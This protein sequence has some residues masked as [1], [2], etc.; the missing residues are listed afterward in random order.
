MCHN[1]CFMCYNVCFGTMTDESVLSSLVKFRVTK[2]KLGGSNLNDISDEEMMISNLP[3]LFANGYPTCLEKFTLKQLEKFVPFMLRCS[4]GQNCLDTYTAPKWWPRD[5][6]FSVFAKKPAGMDDTRWFTTLKG[7]VCRCYTYHGCEF[8]LRFCTELSKCPSSAYVFV[9]SPDGTTS[10]FSKDTGRLV[11]TFR[12]ENRDYD[13]EVERNSHRWLAP[14]GCSQNASHLKVQPP[15]FDIYLCDSC[16]GEFDSLKEVQEHEKTCGKRQISQEAALEEQP[17]QHNQDSFMYYFGLNSVN[18]EYVPRAMSPMKKISCKGR[19]PAGVTFTRCCGVPFSS[20]LG[21]VI[22]KKSRVAA[23]NPQVLLDRMERY[24][25]TKS[26]SPSCRVEDKVQESIEWPITWK[27]PN[28][29]K[30]QNTWIHHYCF[31]VKESLEKMNRKS[32]GGLNKRSQKLLSMCRD[33]RVVLVRLTEDDIAELSTKVL[34]PEL[35][36]RDSESTFQLSALLSNTMCAYNTSSNIKN[37]YPESFVLSPQAVIPVIDLCSTDEEDECSLDKVAH[38]SSVP[39]PSDENDP[40]VLDDAKYLKQKGV[41]VKPVFCDKNSAP[42]IAVYPLVQTSYETCAD[43][44]IGSCVDVGTFAMRYSS[45]RSSRFSKPA[46]RG[47]KMKVRL[48]TPPC[49]SSLHCNSTDI[50]PQNLSS[51]ERIRAKNFNVTSEETFDCDV[52]EEICTPLRQLIAVDCLKLKNAHVPLVRARIDTRG[53]ARPSVP[54]NTSTSLSS[55]STG[56]EKSNSKFS[57]PHRK[58]KLQGKVISTTIDSSI[59][60]SSVESIT[61]S[62]KS[63]RSLTFHKKVCGTS[64]SEDSSHRCQ[65]SVRLSLHEDKEQIENNL[66]RTVSNTSIPVST[67][68]ECVSLDDHSVTTLPGTRVLYQT[69]L[70]N[71]AP[72]S[73]S[74]VSVLDTDGSITID[75]SLQSDVTDF[76]KTHKSEL[77]VRIKRKQSQSQDFVTLSP[78]TKR[79]CKLSQPAEDSYSLVPDPKRPNLKVY[80]ETVPGKESTTQTVC[81]TLQTV[82]YLGCR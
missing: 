11:V 32:S 67:S 38:L 63:R 70:P 4:L 37:H 24:C 56:T 46:P 61:G 27:P 40:L 68:K 42:N 65:T 29:K 8:M 16:D 7:M 62:Q 54:T 12:K 45:D 74:P 72:P 1:V 52:A 26:L 47:W 17:Q 53:K 43:T 79:A 57:F 73:P 39:L 41:K 49:Q 25:V 21:I 9:N 78:A 14:K 81:R 10:L 77:S 82:T 59:S 75:A 60:E 2:L 55:C 31:T 5:L 34:T 48:K 66:F 22:Q 20:P 36:P 71:T 35:V 19:Y 76:V 50:P 51:S 13:K 80:N 58:E 64:S 3:L 18:S 44:E 6:P 15:V 28:Q 69:K 33:V 23:S 30:A